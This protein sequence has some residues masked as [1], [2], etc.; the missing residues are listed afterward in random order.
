MTP[1]TE[2]VYALLRSSTDWERVVSGDPSI[3]TY[4]RGGLLPVGAETLALRAGARVWTETGY[5]SPPRAYPAL[6]VRTL[7]P[8]PAPQKDAPSEE[9]PPPSRRGRRPRKRWSRREDAATLSVR[10]PREVPEQL[11]YLCEAYRMSTGQVIT[12]LV[13]AAYQRDVVESGL[14]AVLAG[15]DDIIAPLP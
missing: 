10:V 3:W 5:D 15:A 7:E 12:R 9:A 6:A 2:Y 4:D 14:I 8:P 13:Q 1:P 11:D